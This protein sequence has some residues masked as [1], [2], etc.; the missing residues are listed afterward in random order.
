MVLADAGEDEVLYTSDGQFAANVEKAVSLPPDA[1]ASPFATFEKV[2]TPD[3][4]TIAAACDVLKCSPTVVV[5]N[6]LYQAVYDN[7]KTVLVL[8]NIRGDQDVN[9]VKLQNA[10]TKLAPEYEARALLA[11]TVPDAEGQQKWAAK[12]LPLGYIAPDLGDDY[13]AASESVVPQFLRLVDKTAVEL[14]N[15]ATGAN[16]PGYHVVGVN[17]GEQFPLPDRVVDIR[18]AMPGDRAAHDPEQTIQS[19]RGIE[20]GHIFQLGSKYSEALGATYT[21]EQGKEDP[22]LMGCYGIGVSRLAQSAVEQSY[23]KD[24]II[25]PVAIAPYRAI[26]CIPNIAAE[27][28]VAA[29]EQLYT[30]LNAAGIETLLDDRKE[31][32]GAKF[33]DADL[34]GIPYRIVTGRSLA[35]G[36]VEVVKRADKSAQEIPLAE[37][38]ATLQQWIAEAVAI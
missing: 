8:V 37:V 17:W 13:I 16:E 27:E 5:K 25:W 29:A 35:D 33:K 12:P 9:E 14:Q 20:V 31:R 38:V 10:L 11:L 18:K 36:N 4:T 15:F 30:D 28:Q 32:A 2:A 26:V 21:N 1:E 6:V 3:T 19:A 22:L 34:L 24:G 23:D 7:G